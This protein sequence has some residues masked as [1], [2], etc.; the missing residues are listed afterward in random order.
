MKSAG[1][2]DKTLS[3]AKKNIEKYYTFIGVLEYIENSVELFEYTYP[4]IFKGITKAYRNILKQRRVNKTPD[5]FRQTVSNVSIEKLRRSLK[6]EF[7]LYQF[8]VQRFTRSYHQA[9]NKMPV[10]S[11]H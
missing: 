9:F 3:I 7:D 6:H 10:L 4:T 8:I 5:E 1:G 2:L 11:Q